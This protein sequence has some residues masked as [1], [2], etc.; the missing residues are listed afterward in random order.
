M[1]NESDIQMFKKPLA[2]IFTFISKYLLYLIPIGSGIMKIKYTQISLW[3][4]NIMDVI[5]LSITGLKYNPMLFKF[6]IIY[7]QMRSK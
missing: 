4:C 2:D 6:Q 7:L 5:L 3:E 1:D